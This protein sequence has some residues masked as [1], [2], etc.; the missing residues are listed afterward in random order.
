SFVSAGNSVPDDILKPTGSPPAPPGVTPHASLPQASLASL[1][2]ED[3]VT[4]G[5]DD[6]TDIKKFDKDAATDP[7]IR[8]YAQNQTGLAQAATLAIT[9]A[10]GFK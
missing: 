10:I 1:T 8:C 5:L 4:E 6:H 3:Q 2:I 7:K 9:H